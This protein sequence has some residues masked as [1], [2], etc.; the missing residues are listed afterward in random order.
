MKSI[1][2]LACLILVGCGVAKTTPAPKPRL[3]LWAWDRAEDLRFLRQGEAE[4]AAWMRTVVLKKDRHN[5]FMRTL[6][7][8]LPPGMRPLEVVRIESDGS[9]KPSLEDAKWLV[10]EVGVGRRSRSPIQIDFDARTSELDWYRELLS[11]LKAE[12]VDVSI[13]ALASWCIDEPWFAPHRSSIREVVPMLYHMGPHASTYM[14]RIHKQGDLANPCRGT[15]G[16]ST[17]EIPAWRP[18]AHTI[19]LFH[20]KR[21]TRE[22]FDDVCARL[23]R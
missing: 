23:F 11:G 1:L 18:P 13:T 6:P 12:G 21:W 5:V 3:V 20:T 16:L 7:L 2:A 15:I 22:A 4:V 19:Y 10:A 14:R 8:Y 9:R 17:D